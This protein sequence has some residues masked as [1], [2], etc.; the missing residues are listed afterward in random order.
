MKPYED[1]SRLGR[2][3]RMKLSLAKGWSELLEL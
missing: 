2:V 1:L 3:H